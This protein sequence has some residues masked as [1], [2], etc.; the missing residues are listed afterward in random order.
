M[1]SLY[2]VIRRPVI[3]EKG[4]ALKER[5]RTLCFEVDT[6]ATKQEIQQAVERI[7]KVRVQGVR[8]MSVRG[9]LRRR[10]RYFGYRPDWK[11]AY[12]TLV[13][14]EKMIEYGDDV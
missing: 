3:T 1:N 2:D 6:A 5:E 7:F 11:K 12:V 13:E 4:L 14:G 10:G 9:K 8:T